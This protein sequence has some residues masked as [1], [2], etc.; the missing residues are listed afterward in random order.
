[1]LIRRETMPTL[2]RNGG[3]QVGRMSGWLD[4]VVEELFNGVESRF[5]PGLNVSETDTHFDVS[6]ELPGMRKEEI[7]ISLSDN[8]LTISGE[9]KIT[10]TEEEGRRFHRVE[11]RFGSF[12]RTLPLPNIIDRDRVEATYE[13]GVLTISIPKLKEKAARKIEVS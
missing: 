9:R 1:M 8:V 5:Y 3:S 4:D 13:N 2:L 10:R 6:V 12:S 7:E 11:S